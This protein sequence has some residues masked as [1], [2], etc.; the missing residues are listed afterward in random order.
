M[1]H[2]R[3][4]G[5][6]SPFRHRSL[7]ARAAAPQRTAKRVSCPNGGQD[8]KRQHGTSGGAACP[9]ET[10]FP[11]NRENHIMVEHW[12][13]LLVLTLHEDRAFPKQ[14]VD[15]GV[16]GYILKR[17]A[18]ENLVAAIRAMASNALHIDPA[19]ASNLFHSGRVN[20]RNARTAVFE[21]LKLTQRGSSRHRWSFR[22]EPGF[23]AITTTVSS[24][25]HWSRCSTRAT[26][27][28]ASRRMPANSS[29]S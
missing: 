3:C 7:K 9:I 21:L 22:L 19:I 20:Q 5:V 26:S 10:S 2:R 16:R 24:T 11:L 14:A 12:V 25:C 23:R 29:G 8:R 13:C 6:G 28:P 18:A 4:F 17:S 15:A 27:K 1:R